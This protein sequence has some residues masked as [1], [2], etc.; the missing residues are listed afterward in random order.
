MLIRNVCAKMMAIAA[1]SALA[2]CSTMTLSS[3][4]VYCEA[5]KPISWSKSDT[6]RT[7]AEVKEHN[8][9]Y[10]RLCE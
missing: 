6:D 8:A 1:I 7:I 2:G 4:V 9:V 3:G 10:K 5:A